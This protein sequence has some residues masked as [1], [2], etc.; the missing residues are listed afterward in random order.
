MIETLDS[1]RLENAQLK[2][3][4]KRAEAYVQESDEM[5][6]TFAWMIE[7]AT[8]KPRTEAMEVLGEMLRKMARQQTARG[9]FG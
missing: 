7:Q 2:A 4:L 6:S 5:R 3:A 9:I 8:T 1:L